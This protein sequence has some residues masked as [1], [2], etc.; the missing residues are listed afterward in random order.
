LVKKELIAARLERLRDYFRTLKKIRAYGL[1]RFKDD[2]FIHS[3]AERCLHLAIESVLDIG[4]HIISDRGYRKPET[5]SEIFEI[6]ADEGVI[7]AELLGHLAGMAA[8]RN[9]L[10][11]DYL[12]IDLD[13]VYSIVEEK[14]QYLEVLSDIYGKLL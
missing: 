10:V 9:V 11:H 4:N 7:S 6:L 2:V 3:T 1:Q 12:R 5:Y 13:R 14:V 8:F